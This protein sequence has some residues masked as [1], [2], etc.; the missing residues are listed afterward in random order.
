MHPCGP[1]AAAYKIVVL[2]GDITSPLGATEGLGM[3]S[4]SGF[5]F[6]RAS[7]QLLVFH[8]PAPPVSGRPIAG[9]P[10]GFP[11]FAAVRRPPSVAMYMTFGSFGSGTAALTRPERRRSWACA[12][13]GRTEVTLTNCH[14]GST[15]APLT[16]SAE[17]AIAANTH[18]PLPITLYFVI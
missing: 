17:I 4:V 13:N 9:M 2:V 12:P 1:S 10:L 14:R 7:S 11:P 15:S 16:P 3:S 18:G 5:Q 8:T 6:G